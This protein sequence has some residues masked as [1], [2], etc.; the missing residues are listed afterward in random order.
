MKRLFALVGGAGA[1]VGGLLAF[2]FDKDL[3]RRRRHVAADRTAAFFRR[4]TRAAARAGRAVSATSYG[5]AQKAKHLREEPKPQPNDATLAR[6]VETEIFRPA[7]APKGTIDV[8]A[9]NGVVFLRGEA[10]SPQMIDDLIDRARK[11]EGVREVE[12]LL[13][14]R[15]TPASSES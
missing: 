13:R 15:E 5:L 8:N 6:K 10:D 14:L 7:D 4:R 2:F 9:E 12:S 1:V 11:V 3:G